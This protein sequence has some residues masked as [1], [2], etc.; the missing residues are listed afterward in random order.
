MTTQ[1][2]ALLVDAKAADTEVEL[3][4]TSCLYSCCGGGWTQRKGRATYSGKITTLAP[5][6]VIIQFAPLGKVQQ[7]MVASADLLAVQ[8]A[9]PL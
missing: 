3:T 9:N 6:Y 5:G 2:D 8:H 7:V 1:N 4:L